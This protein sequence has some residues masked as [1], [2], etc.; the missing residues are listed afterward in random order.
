MGAL[1]FFYF[2]VTNLNKKEKN[3]KKGKK[4]VKYHSLNVQKSL[5]IDTTP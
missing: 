3:E 4:F 2:R 1:L 5:E